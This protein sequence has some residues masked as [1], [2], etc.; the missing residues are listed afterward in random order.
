[1]PPQVNRQVAQCNCAKR[2]QVEQISANRY[3]VSAEPW[4]CRGHRPG[5][6]AAS[7]SRAQPALCRDGHKPKPGGAS[8][9]VGGQCQ[10]GRR[11]CREGQVWVP[12]PMPSPAAAPGPLLAQ[13]PSPAVRG[14]A[15]A[16]DGAHPAQHPHGAGG[17]GLDRPGRVPGEERP[18]PRW[19]RGSHAVPGAVSAGPWGPWGAQI[20][21]LPGVWRCW[22]PVAGPSPPPLSPVKGRTNLKINEKY[23]SSDVFGAAAARCAGNQSTSSSKVLSPSRSNSSLSLYSSAS[24]PS[25]PLARKVKSAEPPLKS[26]HPPTPL[27]RALSLSFASRCC[28][29]RAPGTAVRAPGARGCPTERSCS[30]ARLRRAWLWHPQV[31]AVGLGGHVGQRGC[32]PLPRSAGPGAGELP[33]P[34]LRALAE[35]PEGSSPERCSPCR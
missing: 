15:A 26:R 4:H 1:M 31:S 2:F 12:V 33:A 6:P 25:S 27:P 11:G 32:S 14:V 18:L 16:A 34:A 13:R 30:S 19:V 24:A 17:W 20:P 28:G 23:L 9:P 8:A 29:G 7:A 35:P 22:D 10:R 3:R 5:V 21:A